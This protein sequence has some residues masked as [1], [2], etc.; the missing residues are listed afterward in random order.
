M[1]KLNEIKINTKSHQFL[2]LRIC[3]QIGETKNIRKYGETRNPFKNIFCIL[4][5]KEYTRCIKNLSI[6]PTEINYQKTG[7][8]TY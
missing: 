6:D 1:G 8:P 5:K 4:I 3:F 7:Y 2:K